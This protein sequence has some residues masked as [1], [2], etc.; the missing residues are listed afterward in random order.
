[1]QSADYYRKIAQKKLDSDL[2]EYLTEERSKRIHDK[3]AKAAADGRSDCFVDFGGGLSE[4]LAEALQ[5]YFG[6]LGF[7]TTMQ[8]GG[9]AFEWHASADECGEAEDDDDDDD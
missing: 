2:A 8:Y 5:V 6:E 1:M 7:T 9:I 3:I 4:S